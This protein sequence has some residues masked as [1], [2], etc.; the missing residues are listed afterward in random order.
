LK[1]I[2]FEDQGRPVILTGTA[3]PF[4]FSAFADIAMRRSAPSPAA[5][6]IGA[7]SEMICDIAVGNYPHVAHGAEK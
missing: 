2:W 4:M 3:V 5:D 1:D 7:S 6:V